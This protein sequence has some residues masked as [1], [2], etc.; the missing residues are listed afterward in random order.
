MKRYITILLLLSFVGVLSYGQIPKSPK[1]AVLSGDISG[2]FRDFSKDFK[3]R[4]HF[5]K[6]SNFRRHHFGKDDR[7]KSKSRKF[8]SPHFKHKR[9]RD[10]GYPDYYNDFYSAP[11]Y[12]PYGP[13]YPFYGN[14]YG[15][16]Y[17][18]DYYEPVWPEYNFGHDFE[19]SGPSYVWPEYDFDEPW[20][21]D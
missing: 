11:V 1:G 20:G 4:G 14:P 2:E 5:N 16:S 17:Y 7:D 19:R 3:D 13:G 18:D 15:Y 8:K 21:W 12:P 6:G 10:F 9:H